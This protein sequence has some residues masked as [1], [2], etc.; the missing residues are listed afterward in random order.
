MICPPCKSNKHDN[1]DNPTTCPCQH[2]PHGSSLVLRVNLT[3]TA[4]SDRLQS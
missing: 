2:H 3:S 4:G 1:C